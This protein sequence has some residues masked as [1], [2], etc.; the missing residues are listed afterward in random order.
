MPDILIH[1][2]TNLLPL[3]TVHRETNGMDKRL[4]DGIR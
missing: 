2:K 1:C 4:R 3:K